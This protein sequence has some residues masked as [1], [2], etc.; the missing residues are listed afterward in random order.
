MAYRQACR[1]NGDSVDVRPRRETQDR[2]AASEGRLHFIPLSARGVSLADGL[3]YNMQ[4]GSYQAYRDLFTWS[5]AIPEVADF[6]QAVENAFKAWASVDPVSGFG[7]KLRFHFDPGVPVVGI[8]TGS[9]TLNIDGAEID[10]FGSSLSGV[11][12]GRTRYSR[13]HQRRRAAYACHAHLRGC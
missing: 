5:G 10:L 3:S 13:P 9:G 1:V 11:W 8:S 6:Q 7:T 4:G 2:R 12:G